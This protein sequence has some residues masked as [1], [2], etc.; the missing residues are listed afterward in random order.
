MGAAAD[1]RATATAPTRRGVVT[2]PDPGARGRCSSPGSATARSCVATDRAARGSAPGETL[3]VPFGASALLSGRLTGTDGAGL[4]GRRIEVV[5][6][7]SQGAL[8]QRT[9]QS[10]TTGK[11]GG[12][13]LRLAPGTSRRIA[14]SFAGGDS[15]APAR[16]RPLDLR[17]RSGVT[18]VAAPTKLRTGQAIDSPAACAPAPRR[19]PRRGKLVAIEYFESET[20]RWRPVL[21]T[22]SDHGGRFHARYRFRYVTGAARIRLRATAL[23]EERWPYAPGSS[24]PVTVTVQGR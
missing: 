20:H 17:V 13:S 14:V 2:A 18:L 24:A 21:V 7:P 9:R 19:S 23:A 3:T 10:V 12:F 22:R 11:R 1:G 4:A 8:A 6:R 16:H 15:L 5:S